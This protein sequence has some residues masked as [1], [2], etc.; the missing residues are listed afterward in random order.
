MSNAHPTSL[1]HRRRA[2]ENQMNRRK[3]LQSL[4]VTAAG[5][6]LGRATAAK[7]PAAPPPDS[8]PNRD[9]VLHLIESHRPSRLQKLPS[10]FRDRVGA[11]HVA[12]NYHLTQKPFLLEGAEKL[13]ELGTRLG[14]FWFNPDGVA[15]SYPFNSQWGQYKTF[16]ELARSD[17]FQQLFALPFVTVLLEAHSPVEQGWRRADL[18]EAFYQGV[19]QEFYD[20]TAHL[21]LTYRDRSITIVLQHWEGDWLVRGRGG[22]TWNP[23]PKDWPALCERMVRRLVARQAGVT[24]A[25]AEYGREAKCRVAHAA[26]VNRVADAWND[27]PTV[28]RHVLPAVELDLV[29]YS[30]YDG[31]RDRLTLWKCL[32]DIR[33]HARTGPLFGP[34]AVYIG[35][36]GLPENDQPE[37]LTE[38]WDEW[39][40]V[41]LAAGVKYI[42]HWE[43]YCNEFSRHAAT[44]P[45]TPVTDPKQCRGFWLVKPDG[46]LSESGKY[47]QALW[48]R[49]EQHS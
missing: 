32:A 46:S 17:Y 13:L 36:I 6:G 27:I 48:K 33:Q 5:S 15:A 40:G 25:R 23:P 26:E 44:P 41:L 2:V 22:E 11:T 49:A 20:L 38:R 31:L 45:Q 14:K 7:K 8:L 16:V 37:R 12:G 24:K 34:G 28:T 10:G 43:L 21:Y 19:T 9:E 47:F 39:M 29:S 4:A 42:A 1:R 35:E 3:F 18:K 30:C